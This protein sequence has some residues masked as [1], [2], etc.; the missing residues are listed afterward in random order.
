[1]ADVRVLGNLQVLHDG[2]CRHDAALQ[3]LHA[4]TLQ[5]LGTKMFQEFLSGRLLGKHPVV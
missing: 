1:M 3:V 4:E 5:A 2:T